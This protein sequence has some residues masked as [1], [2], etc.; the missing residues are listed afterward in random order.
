MSSPAPISPEERGRTNLER[1]QQHAHLAR[2]CC[3]PAIPLTLLAQR[4]GATTANAGRIHHAQTAI[5]FLTVF[6]D[7]KR[8]PGWTA[9]RPIG[10]EWKIGPGEAASFPRRVAVA[11]GAYPEVGAVAEEVGRAGACSLRGGRAGA[12][13]V[14]RS[15]EVS[16]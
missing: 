8:L 16:R 12:N 5:N 13:S 1:M 4:T 11:G 15:G 6:L 10:L 3:L 2:L 9:Q 7:T 14:V